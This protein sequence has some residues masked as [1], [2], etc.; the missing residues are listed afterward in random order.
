VHLEAKS[1]FS[2]PPFRC[3]YQHDKLYFFLNFFIFQA[4]KK[5][6]K[7]SEDFI[8]FPMTCYVDILLFQSGFRNFVS[9]ALSAKKQNK[10]EISMTTSREIFLDIF[11]V[12]T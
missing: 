3:F 11:P 12:A 2:V 10:T 5:S 9:R 6:A 4:Q 8:D 1:F 7:T